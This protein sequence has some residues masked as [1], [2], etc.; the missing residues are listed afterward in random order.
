MV[1]TAITIALI[2]GITYFHYLQGGFSSTISAVCALI[3]MLLAF[4]YYEPAMGLFP[5]GKMADYSAGMLLI[6]IFGVSY[7]VLRLIFDG[8]I[9][10]NIRLPLWVDRGCA[11]G[12]G[13]VAAV[14]GVGTFLVGAQL[15]P[16]G[17]SIGMHTNFSLIDRSVVIPSTAVANSRSNVDAFIYNQLE[18]EDL[19]TGGGSTLTVDSMVL[20]IA[21]AASGGAFSGDVKF[22][23][24]HPDLLTEAFANRLGADQGGKRVIINN[25][26]A[27]QV[28]LDAKGVSSLSYNTISAADMEIKKL[29]PSDQSLSLPKDNSK[30][31][32]VVRLRFDDATKDPD[33]YVRMTPAAAPLFVGGTMIYPVGAMTPSGAVALFRIDD[34][35][36]ISMKEQ[37]SKVDLVYAVPTELIAQH[38]STGS[39][40]KG[41][42]YVQAKLFGRVDISGQPLDAAWSPAPDS[43]VLVKKASPLITPP[44]PPAPAAAPA[45]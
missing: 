16:F 39:F 10:G 45:G 31:L 2:A 11:A 37:N 38:A 19:P 14:L 33:D 30:Q 23:E 43:K 35:M 8:L 12:F 34:Q 44:A 5:P 25:S 4:G 29:R 7:I 18:K 9:P 40:A 1:L 20:N 32:L 24:A 3:A 42:A 17:A 27:Q 15:L 41:K 26:K 28:S 13:L 22:A 36:V 6:A 21:S